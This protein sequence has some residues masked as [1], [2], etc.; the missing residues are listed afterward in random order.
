MSQT[1]LIYLQV[2]VSRLKA[3][4]MLLKRFNDSNKRALRSVTLVFEIDGLAFEAKFQRT[5]FF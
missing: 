3:D 5:H 2:D 4:R 1:T